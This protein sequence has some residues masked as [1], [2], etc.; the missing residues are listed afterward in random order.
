M[1]K[2]KTELKT[3]AFIINENKILPK[4]FKLNDNFVG[5][6]LSFILDNP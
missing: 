1:L 6:N 5:Y 2:K 3:F 4:N